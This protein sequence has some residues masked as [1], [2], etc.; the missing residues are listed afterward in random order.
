MGSKLEQS[1]LG[2]RWP[3]PQPAALKPPARA[4]RAWKA[5]SGCLLE[6]LSVGTIVLGTVQQEALARRARHAGIAR[7]QEPPPLRQR[8]GH[9][10]AERKAPAR[11]SAPVVG[12]AVP[13]VDT[14]DQE[15]DVFADGLVE[16]SDVL[17]GLK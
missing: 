10:V 4:L 2:S 17:D 1:W 6:Q 12:D 5:C 3:A 7:R 15:G 9:A 8:V 11:G 13:A 16:E 14:A